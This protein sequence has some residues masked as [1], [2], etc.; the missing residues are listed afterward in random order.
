MARPASL[1]LA[2][3]V[4]T[5]LS[6]LPS[7]TRASEP[8]GAPQSAR[9]MG[10]VLVRGEVF[11]GGYFYDP[12]FGPYPWWQRGHYRYRYEPVYD[13]RAVVRLDAIPNDAAVYVDGFYSGLVDDFDGAR[14]GLPLPPGGHAV[15]LHRPGYRSQHAHL[16]LRP[17]STLALALAL[18]PLDSGERA[19]LRPAVLR[20]P[21]PAPGSYRIPVVRWPGVITAPPPVPDL[22][23]P[24]GW[25]DLHV[26]PS[27]A[28]IAID[29][30]PWWTS[31]PGHVVADLAPGTHHVRVASPACIP[32]D[33]VVEIEEGARRPVSVRLAPTT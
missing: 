4:A 24:I 16:Y 9:S 3:V 26:T 33:L 6:P 8:Q 31:D 7:G 11:V 32:V 15:L 25:L 10:P 12:A 13:A 20:V 14:Q 22:G 28:A 1:I 18:D 23:G 19:E 21:P 17:G 5:L 29:G 30:V 2:G 27:G